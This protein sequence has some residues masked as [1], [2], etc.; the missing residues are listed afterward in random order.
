M[1][2]PMHKYSTLSLALVA[3]LGATA[4][5]QVASAGTSGGDVLYVGYPALVGADLL[6]EQG[7]DGHGVTVAILDSG[8]MSAAEIKRNANGQIRKLQTYNAMTDIEGKALDRSGHGSHMSSIILNSSSPLDHPDK[9]NSIAPAVSYVGV[10]AFG[11]RGGGNYANVIRGLD[12]I[13]QNKD[14]Y[15]IRVVNMSF[16]AAPQSHYWD[17]PLNQAVMALWQAG[18]VVVASA[19]NRARSDDHRRAR[20]RALHH[21]GRSHVRWSHPETPGDDFL[22][23]FSAAGPTYE[24]FVKPELIAPGGHITALM[25]VNST[26][27]A[28][29]PEFHD[30]AKYF[31]MSGTSQSAATVTGVVALMLQAD[32]S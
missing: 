21:H 22:T 3:M 28:D 1:T 4:I 2:R 25:R 19:G 11:P 20:Q 9:F 27:A 18:V 5:P 17:D 15:G 12:W 23:S 31:M 13:L 7:I 14:Q 26:I 32:P 24:G 30:Q 6:H 29:H 10:K 8:N 16:S